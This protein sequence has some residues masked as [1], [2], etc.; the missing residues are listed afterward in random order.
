MEANNGQNI[1]VINSKVENGQKISSKISGDT[2]AN[3]GQNL[4]KK[5]KEI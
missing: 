2:E 5:F 4:N 1:P 3:N